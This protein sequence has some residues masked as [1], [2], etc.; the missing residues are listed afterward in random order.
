MFSVCGFHCF[1]LCCNALMMFSVQNFG[2]SERWAD[3]LH[4]IY[5]PAL[6][7]AFSILICYWAEVW[8]GYMYACTQDKQCITGICVHRFKFLSHLLSPL[9]PSLYLLSHS[10]F[11]LLLLI[12][13]RKDNNHSCITVMFLLLNV[14]LVIHMQ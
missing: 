6:L 5:Y 4:V 13:E 14:L 3:L 8:A 11:A 7:T 12:L 10:T 1:D 2:I 9:S